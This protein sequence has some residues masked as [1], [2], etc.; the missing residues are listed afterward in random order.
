MIDVEATAVDS[1]RIRIGVYGTRHDLD[2]DNAHA[3]VDALQAALR[4]AAVLTVGEH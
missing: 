3:L 1:G 2:V 4:E